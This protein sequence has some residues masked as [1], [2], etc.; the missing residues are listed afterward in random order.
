MGVEHLL[1]DTL[2]SIA[3]TGKGPTL[4]MPPSGFGGDTR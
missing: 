2:M 1:L 4:P 3:Q